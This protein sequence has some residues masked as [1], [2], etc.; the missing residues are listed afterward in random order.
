MS[1]VLVVQ[2]TTE[3]GGAEIVLLDLLKHAR[4]LQ[5][6]R[7]VSLGYGSGPLNERVRALGVP[8]VELRPGGLRRPAVAAEALLSIVR[9]A[10]ATGARAILAHG[11]HPWVFAG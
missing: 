1:N 8:V 2:S 10:R 5:G 3:I 11:S 4:T 6:A 7:M 9:E